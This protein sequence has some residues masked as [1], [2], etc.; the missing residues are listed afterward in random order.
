MEKKDITK[1]CQSIALFC[2]IAGL[3]VNIL[4]L[5]CSG[6]PLS[7]PLGIFGIAFAILCKDEYGKMTKKGR[8]ALILA[9]IALV[10]GF[11][12]YY[13]TLI[14]TTTMADP[15]KS[16]QVLEMLKTIKDQMP[17]EMQDMF[18]NAGIPLE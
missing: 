11:L 16:K 1:S 7:V 17:A 12:L 18:A 9:I 5:S 4:M 3:I 13:L 15:V 10:F 6:V 8:T 14:T 2:A